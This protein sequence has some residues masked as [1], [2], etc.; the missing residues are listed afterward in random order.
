MGVQR[1]FEKNISF[2]MIYPP[3]FSCFSSM[4][5]YIFARKKIQDQKD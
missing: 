5:G 2:I 1:E 3:I 4:K